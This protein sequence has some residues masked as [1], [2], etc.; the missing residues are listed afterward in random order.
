MNKRYGTPINQFNMLLK[1]FYTDKISCYFI[2]LY[3]KNIVLETI[4]IFYRYTYTILKDAF[5]KSM[6]NKS[7]IY[8]KQ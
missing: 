2:I 5:L 8:I 6:I 3:K 1:I 7:S 4:D